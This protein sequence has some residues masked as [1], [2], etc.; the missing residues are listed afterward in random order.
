MSNEGDEGTENSD[1]VE[2]DAVEPKAADTGQ[3]ASEPDGTE[4]AAEE[5]KPQQQR[6]VTS[7]G[8]NFSNW[9]PTPEEM[10]RFQGL[11]FGSFIDP[12]TV[13]LF[14][15]AGLGERMFGALK[16]F[17]AIET[18][19]IAPR[20]MESMRSFLQHNF[21]PPS[22]MMGIIQAFDNFNPGTKEMKELASSIA[23]YAGR[24]VSPGFATKTQEWLTSTDDL[25][26]G[27]N[28]PVWHYTNGYALLSILK[29]RS[30]WASSPQSLNDSSEMD[31][32]FGYI[33][34]AFQE[35]QNEQADILDSTDANEE[36]AAYWE[37]ANPILKEVLDKRY[38][39]SI[40]NEVYYISAS[41]NADSLTLW[42]NYADGDGFAVG[43]DS[44]VKLSAN[45][46]DIDEEDDTGTRS[47]IP[48]VNGWY[49]V[50]YKPKVK[51]RL[52]EGFIDSAIEDIDRA[53]E[54]DRQ[55][56][57][58]E[59]RKQA[60]ILAS[61]M[62]HEAFQ[63]E[64]EVRWITTNFMELDL[65]HYEHGRRSIVPVLHIKTASE[66]RHEPLPLKGVR[67]SPIPDESIVG[68]IEGML[69]KMGYLN[70]SRNVKQSTQPF[71]G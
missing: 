32:G 24:A 41:A 29:T 19:F 31:H 40:R 62:K 4:D 30:L 5:E 17:S 27:W 52:A 10:R 13:S 57:I 12:G 38:F 9:E 6:G 28:H 45:G 70:A 68:T 64:R 61:V 50:Q 18:N 39:S 33:L 63:D 2:P 26:Y 37:T 21:A 60:V 48:P 35:K 23:S 46:W 69:R 56:L 3:E 71:K 43:I 36:D 44:S 1:A 47:E 53:G 20:V 22:G 15:D 66:S 51:Q 54:S 7:R 42:R 55:S 59:L 14:K 16:P 8:I 67:C 25:R 58:N 49:K 11:D 65:V 34:R